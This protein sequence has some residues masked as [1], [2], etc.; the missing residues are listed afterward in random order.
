MS[1]V[2]HSCGFACQQRVLKTFPHP[3][4]LRSEDGIV[5]LWHFLVNLNVWKWKMAIYKISRVKIKDKPYWGFAESVSLM[6]FFKNFLLE[7]QHRLNRLCVTLL[8]SL[9]IYVIVKAAVTHMRYLVRS[10]FSRS[11][12]HMKRFDMI[13]QIVFKLEYLFC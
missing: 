11:L 1:T 9:K 5:W 2:C 3:G 7:N 6:L 8:F 4:Y 10:K 12:V 13:W